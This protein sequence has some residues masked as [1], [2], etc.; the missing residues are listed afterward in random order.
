[1]LNFL[2]WKNPW[3]ARHLI[4]NPFD[5]VRDCRTPST[6]H[7]CQTCLK[8][9]LLTTCHNCIKCAGCQI[10]CLLLESYI[11]VSQVVFVELVLV[12]KMH[13]IC[14]WMLGNQPTR[15]ILESSPGPYHNNGKKH[16]ASK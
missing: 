1:M 15:Y 10:T 4:L 12:L 3:E 5:S 14:C 8:F 6:C 13:K 16:N 2:G 9:L 7:H 11:Q